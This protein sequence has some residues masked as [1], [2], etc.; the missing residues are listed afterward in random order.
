MSWPDC[1]D[2]NTWE[3]DNHE[4]RIYVDDYANQ[5]AIVDAIDYS[6]LVQWRW[7][8]SKSSRSWGAGAKQKLYVSR[9]FS[10]EIGE[11]FQYESRTIR[12]RLH[13]SVYLHQ[14]VMRRAGIVPIS[15]FEKDIIDHLDGNS[16]NCRRS[17]LRW[18]SFSTNIKNKHGKHAMLEAAE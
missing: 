9:T 18:A 16:F 13:S 11:P 2:P 7:K 1:F 14:E 15:L 10:Q 3:V 5:Y 12:Q 17:N 4:Y 8:L 6:Y